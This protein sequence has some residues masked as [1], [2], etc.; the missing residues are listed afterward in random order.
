M[1]F[2]SA[3]WIR[4]PSPPARP[5]IPW[6]RARRCVTAP[7]RG[8]SVAWRS[9]RAH[10][11][12][13]GGGGKDGGGAAGVEGGDIIC[14]CNAWDGDPRSKKHIMLGLARKNRI[15]WVNSIGNRNP[16][17]T[18]GDVRRIARKLW[19]FLRGCRSVAEN[20]YVFSPMV[21]PFHGSRLARRFNRWFLGASIRRVC[22]ALRFRDP[23]TWTFFPTSGDVV[24]TL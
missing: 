16:R 24:G 17:A 9:W 13:A 14:F 22:R 2:C 20:I 1:W 21:I 8:S 6:I 15:L 7:T 4:R 5:R 18:G 3:I 19:Q 12:G 10:W 23:I 11:R